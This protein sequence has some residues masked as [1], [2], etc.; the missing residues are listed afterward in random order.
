MST[1]MS[2]GCHTWQLTLNLTHL[3][4]NCLL[5]GSQPKAFN[6]A[7]RVEKMSLGD[8]CCLRLFASRIWEIKIYNRGGVCAGV[9]FDQKCKVSTRLCIDLELTDGVELIFFINNRQS[10][11][12]WHVTPFGSEH[13]KLLKRKLFFGICSVIWLKYL[14]WN[15]FSRAECVGFVWFNARRCKDERAKDGWKSF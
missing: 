9:T 4:S 6:R 8:L 13:S 5:F 11:Y 1:D 15:T 10:W 2:H 12:H 3:Q 14:N 7:F